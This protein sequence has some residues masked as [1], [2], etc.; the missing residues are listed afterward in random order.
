MEDKDKFERT[1]DGKLTRAGMEAVLASGGSVMLPG[2]RVASLK[3]HLPTV[4]QI[5]G[6]D[7]AKIAA[8]SAVIDEQIKALQAQKDKLG[9]AP[10][11]N[12][13]PSATPPGADKQ[14][15]PPPKPPVPAQLSDEDKKSLE[16][17]N[18]MPDDVLANNAKGLKVETKDKTREQI[19][20]GVLV[21][22]GKP[23]DHA[24]NALPSA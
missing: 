9:N 3:E 18:A 21:A 6:D 10:A 7:P 23:Y 5:V 12:P 20:D 24:G 15:P 13:A 8:T 14:Q 19:I 16:A 4:E 1:P 22:G 2:H 17:I 11:P